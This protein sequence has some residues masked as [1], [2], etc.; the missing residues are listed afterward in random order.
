[1]LAQILETVTPVAVEGEVL[2][3]RGEDPHMLKGL[4]RQVQSVEA[5][6]RD[7]T[8]TALRVRAVSAQSLAARDQAPPQLLSQDRLQAERLHRLRARDPALDTAA[9]GLDL[10]ILE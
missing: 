10:E 1:M 4:Q 8:G 9:E 6:V 3:L 5:V 7:V 2:V